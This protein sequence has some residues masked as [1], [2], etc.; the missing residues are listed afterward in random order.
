MQKYKR[1]LRKKK[2]RDGAK[3]GCAIKCGLFSSICWHIRFFT[4]SLETTYFLFF[5][6]SVGL[7]L[8]PQKQEILGEMGA[9][10]I[11]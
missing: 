6:R 8:R 2:S 11:G 3:N 7:I 5:F 9:E 1:M 10:G 4:P